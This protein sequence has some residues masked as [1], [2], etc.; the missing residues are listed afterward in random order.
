MSRFPLV[1]ETDG[2]EDYALL[3]SGHGRKLER[4][5][6]LTLDRPEEQAVWSP[7]L[8][9]AEWERADAV[10][11]GDVDEEGAGRWKRRPGLE[12]SW[13][14]RHGPI[15]FS[16]RFTSFRHV[17]AFPE[18]EAHWSWMRE[19]LAQAGGRP[20]LLNLFGYTGLASLIAAEAGAEVTHVDASKKA[21]TWARENQALSSLDDR[22]I[23]WILDDAGKFAARDVRR[24]RRYDGVLLD[25]PKYGRG[26]KGEVWDLFRDLPEMLRLC[27]ALVAPG[28]F[29]ILTA[30]AIRASFLSMHRLCE[31]IFG[32]GVESGELALRQKGGGLLATSLFSRWT[33][34]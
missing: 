16:C 3:D 17:G 24:G 12:E 25:P 34:G 22:P 19:R 7:R 32:P 2:L 1:L 11:T 5:G 26:P 15:R 9:A 6:A 21:I 18:Q 10:F 27:R 28:G 8:P 31:E 20:S 30:Y 4:F 29:V 33:A 23:R 14:C 13:A